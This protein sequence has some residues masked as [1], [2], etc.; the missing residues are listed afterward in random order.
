LLAVTPTER[1]SSPYGC[2][3]SLVVRLRNPLE[4]RGRRTMASTM[5]SPPLGQGATTRRR[6][7]TWRRSDNVWRDAAATEFQR[8][9][10]S[11][12]Q[13]FVQYLHRFWVAR[14]RGQDDP[15]SFSETGQVLQAAP[16]PLR[17]DWRRLRRGLQMG[18]REP[19]R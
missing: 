12:H 4:H 11:G 1:C 13:R 16:F 8:T 2:A 6:S 5:G 7:A 19:R 9:S 18:A 15:R 14:E 17:V 3:G 10:D